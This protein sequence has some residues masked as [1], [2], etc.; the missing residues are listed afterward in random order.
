ME[1]IIYYLVQVNGCFYQGKI[2]SPTFTNDEEQAFAFTD[3]MAAFLLASE[4]NGT[5]LTREVSYKELEEISVLQS[6]EYEILPKNERDKIESFCKK[7]C[8][9]PH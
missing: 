4:V 9:E 5:V 3:I 2:D 7:L 1:S 8:I 6:L